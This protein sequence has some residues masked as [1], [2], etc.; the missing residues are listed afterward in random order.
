MGFFD[1][2]LD[3]LAFTKAEKYPF[4]FFGVILSGIGAI[5]LVGTAFGDVTSGEVLAAGFGLLLAGIL[6]CAYG[7][8][9]WSTDKST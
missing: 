8:W 7:I 4:V 5:I 1:F 6:S 3:L 2:I 9:R